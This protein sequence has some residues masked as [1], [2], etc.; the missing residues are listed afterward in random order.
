HLNRALDRPWRRD[1][2]GENRC[3][4]GQLVH[5][6]VAYIAYVD[7]RGVR[8]D[9]RH[10]AGAAVRARSPHAQALALADGE[11]VH[12]VVLSQHRTARID[13]GAAPNPDALTQKSASIPRRDEADVVTVRLVGNRETATGRLRADLRLGGVSDRECGVAQ[14]LRGQHR[15]HVGLVL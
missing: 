7:G 13:D 15:E 5:V 12:P 3:A 6:E 2:G 10:V 11:T 14:L 1:S 8:V 4:S 9:G